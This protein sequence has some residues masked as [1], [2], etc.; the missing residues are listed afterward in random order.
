MITS[1][2]P[3]TIEATTSPGYGFDYG[4][5]TGRNAGFVDPREQQ[6]M[7]DGRVFVCGVG[8]MG[9]AALAS[10]VRAGVGEV[11]LAD[12][13]RF[14]VSNMNR[15]LFA[16]LETVGEH[17]TDA[18]E[19]QLHSVNPELTVRT[20]G[21]DWTG[22]VDD[23]LDRCPVVVNGMDDIRAT[24]LLYRRAREHRATVIDAYM[25]PLPSVTVVRPDDPSPEERLGFPTVG[26]P[27]D[28][29]THIDLEAC[30]MREVEYVLTHSTSD[31]HV[32]MSFAAGVLS[33]ARPRMSFAPSVITAGTLMALEAIALL[34]GKPTSTDHR[35]YFL[36]P[37]DGRV[38]RPR[39]PLAAWII[40]RRVR[41]HLVALLANGGD[42]DHG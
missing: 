36:N 40:R 3:R 33:G 10:I 11:T 20:Y 27:L 18:T 7:R 2:A 21:S 17:K 41:R 23:I 15:Q 42:I 1:G 19:R 25:S 39:H 24:L 30:Q 35:G 9:G 38:E 8:G 14:E 13:D 26:K 32:D 12:H 31:K 29:V 6:R 16:T 28:E 34:I 22:H 37:W 4:V 5:F